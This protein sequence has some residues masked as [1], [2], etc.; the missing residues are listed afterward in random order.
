MSFDRT[1]GRRARG[2][3]RRRG[4]PLLEGQVPAA[5]RR[6]RDHRPGQDRH[7][8][9]KACAAQ[10]R[11]CSDASER[12][13]C[14]HVGEG[15]NDRAR[16]GTGWTFS[17]SV[18][19]S[20]PPFVPLPSLFPL[21]SFLLSLSSSSSFPFFITCLNENFL[22]LM[23]VPSCLGSAHPSVTNISA[24]VSYVHFDLKCEFVSHKLPYF[25]FDFV[26]LAQKP[27]QFV[28]L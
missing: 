12:G 28:L 20:L 11:L 8:D 23:C 10:K 14:A 15:R 3:L 25:D 4:V 5:R 21:P 18:L 13:L 1:Q 17:L 9:W 27:L 22:S 7:H 16:T 24:S 2:S 26:L 6:D 19:F